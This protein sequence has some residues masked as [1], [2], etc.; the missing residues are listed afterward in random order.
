MRGAAWRYDRCWA[1]IARCHHMFRCDDRCIIFSVVFGA[2][3]PQCCH[4]I[5]ARAGK[6]AEQTGIDSIERGRAAKRHLHLRYQLAA[7]QNVAF[8]YRSPPP[9]PNP[10]RFMGNKRVYTILHGTAQASTHTHT[11]SHTD[12]EAFTQDTHRHVASRSRA[13]SDPSRPA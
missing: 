3:R 8:L 9:H 4:S 2:T 12:S 5:A 11:H 1:G 7:G 13:P 10:L 6:R